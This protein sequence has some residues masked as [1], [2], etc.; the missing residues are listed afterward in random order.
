M[1]LQHIRELLPKLSKNYLDNFMK[2]ILDDVIVYNEWI[3]I[4]RSSNYVFKSA[5]NM[6]L[7]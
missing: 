5:K 2:I 1:E 7:V 3:I 6:A 4:Y